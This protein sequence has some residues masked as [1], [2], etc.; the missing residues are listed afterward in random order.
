[1]TKKMRELQ[2]LILAKVTEAKSLTEGETK[3]IEKA[4]ALL[5]EAD[6]LEKELDILA[7]I[8]AKEKAKVPEADFEK[9]E[10]ETDCIKAFADAARAR[11]KTMNETTGA[12]GGYTVPEDIQ[13]MINE[14]KEARFS[15]RSLIDYETVETKSGRRTYKQRAQHTGFT[16]VAEG[17]KK[18]KVAAPKFSILEYKIKKY[19][20]YLPVTN[21]LLDDSDAAIVSTVVSWLGEESIATENTQILAKVNTKSST[22][23]NGLEDIKKAINVTLAA[24]A[25]T[26]KIITNSDGL[27]YL[28]TLVD[29]NG[30]PLLKPDP[31]QPLAMHLAVGVRS[32]PLVIIPNEVL[33]TTGSGELP[34]IMGDLREY[35]K[36]FD[37]EQLTIKQSDVATVGDFNAFEQDMTIFAGSMRADFVVKDS[38]AIV[39]GTLTPTAA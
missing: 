11:F 31:T 1:M 16:E 10:T 6:A 8:E 18:T 2:A 5:E 26:V 14:Y 23:L 27:Q 3:D 36:E 39:R 9:K 20:G 30:K 29:G 13:T 38:A 17:G 33:P 24:F 35:L 34:F 22:A 25:G 28:D 19:S 32:I 37:R 21:E 15:L 4:S 7:K 12:D